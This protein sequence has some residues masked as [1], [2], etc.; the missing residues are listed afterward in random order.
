[1]TPFHQIAVPAQDGIRPDEKPQPAQDLVRQR[2]QQRGEKGPVLGPES[3]PDAGAELPFKN[4]DLVA[5]GENLNILVPIP[6]RSAVKAFV[7]AR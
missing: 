1:M 7:T 3:H 6:H 4:G 5:Q 2:G